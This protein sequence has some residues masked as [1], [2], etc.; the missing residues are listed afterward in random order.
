MDY[1]ICLNCPRIHENELVSYGLKIAS[2]YCEAKF[3]DEEE[4]S[5]VMEIA[6]GTLRC[7]SLIRNSMFDSV[8]MTDRKC[9]FYT[10]HM[11]HDLSRNWLNRLASRVSTFYIRK[12]IHLRKKYHVQLIPP[13]M[14]FFMIF[15]IAMYVLFVIIPFIVTVVKMCL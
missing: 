3:R 11:L 8:E 5:D 7:N 10:E 2:C 1:K 13:I 12:K 6:K 15:L 14:I 4:P 9:D